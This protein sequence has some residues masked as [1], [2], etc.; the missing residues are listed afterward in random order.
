MIRLRGHHLFC[1]TLFTGHGYDERFTENMSE[2][3]RR[4]TEGSDSKILLVAEDDSVCAACPNLEGKYCDL[5]NEDVK[6]RDCHAREA[7]SIECGRIYSYQELKRGLAK[8]NE[9][10]FDRVCANCTWWKQGFCSYEMFRNS[11]E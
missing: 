3:L 10:E 2:L 11:I 4:L 1:M 6:A 9:S 8:V 5:G 7:L